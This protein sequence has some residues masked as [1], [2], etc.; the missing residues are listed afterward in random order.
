MEYSINKL[1]K[2]AG[3]STRTLRYYDQIGLLAPKRISSNGYRIYGQKQVDLLQQIMF[4]RELGV[5]LEQIKKIITSQDY[6]EINSLRNHLTALEEKKI[7]L[8]IMIAGVKKTIAAAKG[9][10]SMSNSEKFE[11]FKKKMVEE[12]EFRFGKEARERFGGDAIDSGNEMLM[13]M[14][15]TQ[16]EQLQDLTKRINE[17]LKEAFET[18]DPSGEKAQEVCCLHKQWLGFFWKSYT[19]EAHMSLA[20]SYVDDPRFKKYYDDIAAGC[21]EFLRDALLIYLN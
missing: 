5:E 2:L 10:I 3:V 19:K 13:G 20:Q 18:G 17:G 12:N 8:D 9:E 6:D 15:K 7:K 21:A 4:Y 14:S 1:A 11:V 16:Y